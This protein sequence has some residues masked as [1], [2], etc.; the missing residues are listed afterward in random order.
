MAGEPPSAARPSRSGSWSTSAICWPIP[1][2]EAVERHR[3][4]Q[5]VEPRRPATAGPARITQGHGEPGQAERQQ[6]RRGRQAETEPPVEQRPGQRPPR[7]SPAAASSANSRAICEPERPAQPREPGAQQRLLLA[8]RSEFG[9]AGR[10]LG[11]HGRGSRRR[12]LR[13]IRLSDHSEHLPQHPLGGQAEDD[14]RDRAAGHPRARRA[15]R[16]SA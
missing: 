12:S 14:D 8:E 3:Q 13:T 11:G 7:P 16:G 4:R 15:S 10:C 1:G 9:G 2:P 5:V 6:D